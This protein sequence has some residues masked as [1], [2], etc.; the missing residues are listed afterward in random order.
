MARKLFI[1]DD[2]KDLLSILAD[3]FSEEDYSVDTCSDGLE[4]IERCR[5]KAYD[6]I[7]TDIML[8][9]ASGIEILREA[10][11][12]RPETLVIL[13]TGFASLETAINAIREGAYD[14]ITK[15]FKLE[16]IKIAVNNAMDKISLIKE[17]RKLLSLLKRAYEEL[18]LVKQI[19]GTSSSPDSIP[20]N[21]L[22]GKSA[23]TL[24]SD[25][26]TPHLLGGGKSASSESF[27]S[28]LER[29][30]LLRDKGLITA[31]EFE[32]CKARLFQ[33]LR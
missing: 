18:R 33:N 8:P 11:K 29:I 14:Y 1:V 12:I 21:P 4:A 6:L 27:V 7:I 28:D 17:N 24:I 20:A 15:P 10:K 19:L 3:V 26:L 31:R 32:I 22:V 16:Q 9:G 23:R 25:D 2:D 5:T 13:I 30:S